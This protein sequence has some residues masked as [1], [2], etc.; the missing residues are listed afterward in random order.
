METI[1]NANP[2]N[3]YCET[4][5][6]RLEY[7]CLNKDCLERDN[8]FGCEKCIQAYHNDH[9]ESMVKSDLNCVG[10]KDSSALN[11]SELSASLSSI[12]NMKGKILLSINII[13][14][15]VKNSS[16]NVEHRFCH[17]FQKAIQKLT[18][19][20]TNSNSTSF[21]S[22]DLKIPKNEQ[23]FFS[24]NNSRNTELKNLN[25]FY[26][27]FAKR[28][29]K[30]KKMF[31]NLIE[32]I[33]K[34]NEIFE[35]MSI[36]FEEN[37]QKSSSYSTLDTKIKI[38][39]FCSTHTEV[40]FMNFFSKKEVLPTYHDNEIMDLKFLDLYDHK[41]KKQAPFLASCS[42]DKSIKIYDLNNK[43]LKQSIENLPH[44]IN[45]L[46][47]CDE[48]NILAASLSNDIVKIYHYSSEF[49]FGTDLKGH[50]DSV[51]GL[52]FLQKGTKLLSSS[53]D[54]SVR[55]WDLDKG[56]AESKISLR[57]GKVY[58]IAYNYDIGS[59]AIAGQ[60]S[61]FCLDERDLKTTVFSIKNAHENQITKLDYSHGFTKNYLASSGKD[62]KIKLWDI[63]KSQDPVLEFYHEDYVY[64][65][66]FMGSLKLL[67]TASDDKSVK[68]WNIEEKKL[69]ATFN[70]H[71]DFVKTCQWEENAKILAYAGKDKKI[72][73]R[74]YSEA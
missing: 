35:E 6:F 44:H 17:S 60:N 15:L 43:R 66:S 31:I 46:A 25:Q 48:S 74:Y 5:K 38:S 56:K 18:D 45:Q 59:V 30:F 41:S 3:F 12:N 42:K 40:P 24:K 21:Y 52:Q 28:F 58:G 13:Q 39:S 33:K 10:N 71:S 11:K 62:T 63:R 26:R 49:N 61:I 68:I 51:W 27:D 54:S 7:L 50:T 55:L 70:D 23:F 9:R 4:H 67:A 22:L 1:F 73:L 20:S 32:V 16:Q 34:C 64:G 36:F 14:K 57:E 2:S 19:D 69:A 37:S 8:F 29:E 47:F 72:V 53:F 65:L